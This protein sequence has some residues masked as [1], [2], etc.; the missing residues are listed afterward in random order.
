MLPG[1]GDKGG[2]HSVS[3]LAEAESS[4]PQQKSLI[5]SS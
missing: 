3:A 5:R 2:V 4:L 1:T